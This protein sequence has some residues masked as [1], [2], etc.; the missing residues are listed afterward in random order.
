MRAR[1]TSLNSTVYACLEISTAQEAECCIFH[2][3]QTR[4]TIL[5]LQTL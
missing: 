1:A 5:N 3:Q 4:D 2:T